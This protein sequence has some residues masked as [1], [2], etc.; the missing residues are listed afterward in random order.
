MT[1][2]NNKAKALG[3]FLKSRR[4]RLSPQD[5]KL[6]FTQ[7]QRK[8]PGLRREEVAVLSGVSL[9]YYT[10]LEQGRDLNPSKDVIDSIAQ[11]LQLSSA[12]KSHLHQLWNP[13]LSETPPATQAVVDPQMQAIID[14]LTYP[15]HITNEKSEVLAW[16]KA[17]QEAFIDF[18]S[19]PV[20]ERYFI[21]LLFK[22]QE[23]RERIVNLE[24]FSNYSV[25]V[26]RTYYDKYKNDPWFEQTV[27]HLIQH[28]AEFEQIWR[29]YEVQV[30]KD[31]QVILRSPGSSDTQQSVH[32]HIRSL[33][34]FSESTDMHTC[35][36]TPLT[37]DPDTA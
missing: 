30:K 3:L 31:Q 37:E 14:Q 5:V 6:K 27:E 32:Y 22:N 19:I 8:T 24:E 29:Q 18:S 36:Y 35:I 16:N 15:C 4:G 25:G 23:L 20:Q 28:S 11:A 12:E 34:Y 17:A 2:T 33:L 1:A 13:H 10:W 26:F 21:R 9:T 7:G